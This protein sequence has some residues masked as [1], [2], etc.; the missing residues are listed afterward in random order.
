MPHFLLIRTPMTGHSRPSGV[1]TKALKQPSADTGAHLN[2]TRAELTTRS[3][4]HIQH[5]KPA[6]N[7]KRPILTNPEHSSVCGAHVQPK[8][9]C[10][11]NLHPPPNPQRLMTESLSR[12]SLHNYQRNR[13][14]PP[15]VHRQTPS[16]Y[17]WIW[18]SE[19][20]PA[21]RCDGAGNSPRAPRQRGFPE[22][23]FGSG[24][25]WSLVESGS[26]AEDSLTDM[27]R[28]LALANRPPAYGL[29]EIQSTLGVVGA[30]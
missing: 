22:R 19:H 6:R 30:D 21:H 12:Q 8:E 29:M 17:N 4:T 20:T 10:R 5:P 15:A 1:N 18:F 14:S 24:R 25:P 26:V 2:Q 7:Q 3:P 16:S 9:S 11:K 13:P 27:E 23:W 28:R